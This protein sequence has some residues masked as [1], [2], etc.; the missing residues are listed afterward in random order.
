MDMNCA[1]LTIILGSCRQASVYFDRQRLLHELLE[2]V[3]VDDLEVVLG[4]RVLVQDR[5]LD[6]DL[7]IWSTDWS[8]K[9]CEGHLV[10]EDC[11]N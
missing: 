3:K 1:F 11:G 6:I 4:G 9:F 10:C 8:V 2:P 5:P 7:I